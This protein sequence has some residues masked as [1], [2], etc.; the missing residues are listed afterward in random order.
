[1]KIMIVDDELEG[2]SAIIQGIN[3]EGHTVE[4]ISNPYQARNRIG[5]E[6]LPFQM[7]IIDKTMKPDPSMIPMDEYPEPGDFLRLGV[8]LVNQI[9]AREPRCPVIF[10]SAYLDAQDR[11]DLGGF[12]NVVV[13][14]KGGIKIDSILNV[15]RR[16]RYAVN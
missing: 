13:L 7:A 16:L 5:A 12:S 8:T 3:G 4:A 14:D 6:P 10:L 1:M 2:L 15:I 9:C 11:K